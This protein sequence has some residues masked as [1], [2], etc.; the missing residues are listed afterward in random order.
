MTE[1]RFVVDLDIPA[2]EFLRLYNGSAN[3]V[4]A[5]DRV[6]GKTVR[7]PA[8]RLRTFVSAGG[9]HGRFEIV[10]DGNNRLIAIT[11]MNDRHV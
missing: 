4:L 5:R 11:R 6:T 2:D 8:S 3:T 1:K 9:V 10:T 7:F